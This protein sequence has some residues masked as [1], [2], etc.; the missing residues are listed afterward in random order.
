MGSA[1]NPTGVCSSL[2]EGT[3]SFCE[4]E[5][6]EQCV[7][8]VA[9][10]CSELH[11]GNSKAEK[12][13]RKQC[14][15]DLNSGE[16]LANQSARFVIEIAELIAQKFF[17]PTITECANIIAGL[18]GFYGAPGEDLVFTVAEAEGGDPIA[19]AQKAIEMMLQAQAGGA[20]EE[21]VI[22]QGDVQA[23]SV[24]DALTAAQ[25]KIELMQQAQKDA[26]LKKAQAAI[27]KMLA[28]Q[29]QTAQPTPVPTPIP[30]PIPTPTPA[31]PTPS[32]SPEAG[33]A[34]FL[35]SA[36]FSKFFL[37]GGV[38]GRPVVF[39]VLNA[40]TRA[41]VIEK[42]EM[43]QSKKPASE[44]AYIAILDV[45]DIAMTKKVWA[46]LVKYL[47]DPKNKSKQS[48]K[49][50]IEANYIR[51]FA[52]YEFK[53]WKV[54][55][56]DVDSNADGTVDIDVG[57][58]DGSLSYQEIV[59]EYDPFTGTNYNLFAMIK[60]G[61]VKYPMTVILLRDPLEGDLQ[62]RQEVLGVINAQE[63]KGSVFYLNW[64]RPESRVFAMQYLGIPPMAD[65]DDYSIW[66]FPNPPDEHGYFIELSGLISVGQTLSELA[67]TSAFA[68]DPNE[69]QYVTKFNFEQYFS[70]EERE[71]SIVV[72]GDPE[73]AET[74]R[75][76]EQLEGEKR[77]TGHTQRLIMIPH[78]YETSDNPATNMGPMLKKLGIAAAVPNHPAAFDISW[79]AKGKPVK[80]EHVTHGF[81]T[82]H[83]LGHTVNDKG[84]MKVI[85]NG[86]WRD[87]V[88]GTSDNVIVMV[89]ETNASWSP[90]I[91]QSTAA[92]RVFLAGEMKDGSIEAGGKTATRLVYLSYADMMRIFAAG[93]NEAMY[94]AFVKDPQ[95]PQMFMVSGP[96][97][98]YK[99]GFFSLTPNDLNLP[100]DIS[101][102]QIPSEPEV[103][104]LVALAKQKE[105]ENYSKNMALLE[106]MGVTE[107]KVVSDESF[108]C[109]ILGDA[110]Q[111]ITPMSSAWQ[112][113]NKQLVLV[114]GSSS[115]PDVTEAKSDLVE[116]KENCQEERNLFFVDTTMPSA[117]TDEFN[118]KQSW[119]SK[120]LT[121]VFSLGSADLQSAYMVFECKAKD[122][123]SF[124]CSPYQFP[125]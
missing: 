9:A 101:L 47:A 89:G 35:T 41:S 90:E 21:M 120:L 10:I 118:A 33:K 53:S 54:S 11:P 124:S 113:K 34:V 24:S 66:E 75:L 125:H 116:L 117:G 74:V 29:Q 91:A 122:K 111:Q 48:A 64:S 104:D 108:A 26:A 59:K 88:I 6:T 79:N 121:K 119:L 31:M 43:E 84:V 93:K 78:T 40:A 109:K 2:S 63:E 62:T 110:F 25:K 46:M 56:H 1:S 18:V 103:K 68:A 69:F 76:L 5:V 14:I 70:E 32:D 100:E 19:K 80:S 112:L 83:I 42:L 106:K 85:D 61:K 50:L 8:Q 72:V 81:E 86:V 98:E 28:A 37:P 20:S 17:A 13:A 95:L 45:G 67:A 44:R 102:G 96:A 3:V 16:A 99:R 77:D 73:D 92:I 97:G 22:T 107:S 30:V 115:D 36:N 39:A 114:V 52:I 38:G 49:G 71:D 94:N 4:Q 60:K 105:A 12:K 82:V 87:S 58:S 23:D 123:K 55:P 65:A 57:I 7:D 27:E 15:A 51:P